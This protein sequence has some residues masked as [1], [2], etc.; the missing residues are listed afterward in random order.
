MIKFNRVPLIV[1]AIPVAALALIGTSLSTSGAGASVLGHRPAAASVAGTGFSGF[2]NTFT[3]GHG[4]F[5][6]NSAD[7]PCDGQPPS[8]YGTANRVDATFN[9][10]GTGNYAAGTLPL[11]PNGTTNLPFHMIID[12]STAANQGNPCPTSGTEGCTGPYMEKAPG[13]VN[14]QTVFPANGYTVTV[15]QYDDPSYQGNAGTGNGAAGQIDTDMG[16]TKVDNTTNPPTA[17]YGADE[18][19][20]TCPNGNG[21][22]SVAFG[23]GSPGTCGSNSDITAPGWYRYVFLVNE[24]GGNVFLD[25]R[26]LS[27]DGSTVEFDSGSVPVDFGSG[28]VTTSETGGLRYLWWPTLNADGLPVGYV[29]YS[30]GQQPSGHAS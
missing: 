6:D 2:T 13:G 29:N 9:N 7:A 17:S 11:L 12:G 22:E 15:Y 18:I 26:V 23:H 3:K 25:A 19:L 20:T 27:A 5:C 14:S 10:G 8:D 16:I 4:N 1:A 21:T 30:A 24:V 28:Q